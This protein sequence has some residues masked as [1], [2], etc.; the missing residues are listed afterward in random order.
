[1]C[2]TKVKTFSMWAKNFL[3]FFRIHVSHY[4]ATRSVPA[5]TLWFCISN[6]QFTFNWKYD[7]KAMRISQNEN[8][9][10]CMKLILKKWW[11]ISTHFSP[12]NL[13]MWW[14]YASR[15]RNRWLNSFKRH[16]SSIGVICLVRKSTS[17]QDYQPS[18]L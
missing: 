15:W 3:Y 8:K 17:N 5:I 4:C 1:M 10:E 13:W 14:R 9:W 6:T 11:I 18:L 7:N 16:F 2:A 12:M